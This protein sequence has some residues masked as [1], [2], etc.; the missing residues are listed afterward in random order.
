MCL[1]CLTKCVSYGQVFP[2]YALARATK[3]D[4]PDHP[5]SSSWQKD[6]YALIECNDPTFIFNSNP[7]KDDGSEAYWEAGR[8]FDEDIMS[9]PDARAVHKLIEAAR[10]EGYNPMKTVSLAFG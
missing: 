1:Q 3:T 2:G 5:D 6:Q 9:G 8:Q 7:L 4:Y 10:A